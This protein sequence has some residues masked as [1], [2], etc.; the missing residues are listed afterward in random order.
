MQPVAPRETG[1][2]EVEE[3]SPWHDSDQ[4][5]M[6]PQE[7]TT[8]STSTGTEFLHQL[9]LLGWVDRTA[10]AVLA[11]FFVIG[12]FKG[13]IWQVSR[14]GILVA[15]YVLA[16]RY[17]AAVGAF[18]ARTPAVGGQ[19]GP[20]PV[21]TPGTTLYLAYV[22]V[23]LAVLV[24]LSLLAIVVQKLAVKAGLGF[25]DRL[26]GGLLGFATGACVVLF[27]LSIVNMFFRGSQFAVAAE[28]SHSL[29][30]TR[31]A[32]GLLG[33][34]V[35]DDLRLVFAL[36]PL[37]E[38]PRDDLAPGDAPI[39]EFPP[40]ERVDDPGEGTMPPACERPESTP[41]SQPPPWVSPPAPQP[42]PPAQR[43]GR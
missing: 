11:V 38:P 4:L 39:G 42:A 22:L 37:Q 40:G 41:A 29:R 16:G 25:F 27:G 7:P 43:P 8:T 17:G 9:E 34:S 33:A 3:R 36:A 12:L 14:I 26:G 24:V 19:D 32:I 20:D 31:Q 6:H 5:G 30:L 1:N 10:L 18:L 13:L 21:D 28:S 35:P 2:G 15:A 23:F